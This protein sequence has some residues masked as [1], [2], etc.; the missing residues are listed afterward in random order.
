[1]GLGQPIQPD[2]HVCR[3]P[4]RAARPL[5]DGAFGAA[6]DAGQAALRPMQRVKAG[7]ELGGGYASTSCVMAQNA[8]TMAHSRHGGVYPHLKARMHT[9][10]HSAT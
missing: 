7:A 6:K 1:M 2:G 5:A 9:R 4:H 10:A 8:L 3:Y